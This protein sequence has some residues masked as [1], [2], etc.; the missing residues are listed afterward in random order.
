MFLF[1]IVDELLSLVDF[2]DFLYVVFKIGVVV[3]LMWENFLVFFVDIFFFGV[4]DCVI[5]GSMEGDGD[6]FIDRKVVDF[7]GY[8]WEGFCKSI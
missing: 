2:G 1:D 3:C 4:M 5:Y 6:S 8:N 7:I